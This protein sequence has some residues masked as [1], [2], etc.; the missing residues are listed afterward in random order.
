M[1]GKYLSYVL[2]SLSENSKDVGESFMKN[3][4]NRDISKGG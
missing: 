4:E 1:L 3:A 2:V